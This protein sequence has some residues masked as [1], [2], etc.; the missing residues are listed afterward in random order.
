MGIDKL[1]HYSLQNPASVYDEEA[2]TAL[3]LA[4]RTAGKTNECVEALNQMEADLP[5]KVEAAVQR[6]IDGGA[7]D[8]QVD[9]FAGELAGEIASVDDK[10][11]QE[12]TD[13]EN[14]L[15]KRINNIVANAGDGS[16][17]SEVVDARMDGYGTLNT[18][19]S[20]SIK[21][22]TKDAVNSYTG[23]MYL[24]GNTPISFTYDDAGGVDIYIPGRLSL[25]SDKGN[26]TIEW[27]DTITHIAD[28]VTF[29]ENST[30]T[31]TIHMVCYKSLVYNTLEKMFRLR[32]GGT[33]D[34]YDIVLVQ[35]GYANVTRGCLVDEH[36]MKKL[37]AHQTEMYKVRGA[38]LYLGNTSDPLGLHFNVDDV[39]ECLD[40]YFIGRPTLCWGATY[41]T[42]LW[43][44]ATLSDITDHVTVEN[45]TR[46]TIHIP[47]WNALVYNVL[48]NKYHLRWRAGLLEGDVLAIATGYC[49]PLGG[50][51]ID[52]WNTKRTREFVDYLNSQSMSTTTPDSVKEFAALFNNTDNAEGFLFFTDPHLCE[53]QE[54]Q[55]EFETYKAYLK[56]INEIAP[57]SFAICGGDWLGNGDTQAEACFK[58]GLIDRQMRSI[59]DRYYP[60]LGNHDT[61]YQG[62]LTRESENGTGQ[63]SQN[64]LRNLWFKEHGD[65]YY[66]FRGHNTRFL[67]FDTGTDWDTTFGEFETAQMEWAADKLLNDPAEHNAFTFHIFFNESVDDAGIIPFARQL[68]LMADAF[69]N[70]TTYTLSDKSFDFSGATGKVHFILT[71]HRHGDT[72][73]T[74]NNIPVAVTTHTRNGG[75]PTFELCFADYDKGLLH[76][77]RVGTGAAIRTA[78]I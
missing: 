70:R 45:N 38:Y 54:W 6:H 42:I 12:I 24:G 66:Q 75:A 43:D 60:V 64:T 68:T 52:E 13:V 72:L 56:S 7:F 59:F 11:S 57:V 17:P 1:N 55:T 77:V 19:L 65:T 10:L 32:N 31:V 20:E 40:V 74:V 36:Q 22:Q 14:N 21:K 73:T 39:N 51:L 5:D 23:F 35:N 69:N 62:K 78:N 29:A 9:E 15:N 53:G 25:R 3:E 50:T 27:T 61:N 4:A 71:G 76:L 30:K 58:L 47:G 16:V 67:V 8:Q 49:Q 37:A 46:A 48:D 2:L 26:G 34:T 44:E 33:C 28:N 41:K 63:L 18:S